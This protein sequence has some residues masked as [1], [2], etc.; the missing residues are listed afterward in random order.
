MLELYVFD[1]VHV[2][3]VQLQV[4]EQEVLLDC[5]EQLVL[6]MFL[7]VHMKGWKVVRWSDRGNVLQ[8]VVH[9]FETMLCILVCLHFLDYT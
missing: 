1:E 5:M 9:I 6:G 2:V 7:V 4:I 8:A 3:D